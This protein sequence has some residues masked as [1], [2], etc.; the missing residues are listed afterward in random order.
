M[1]NAA[2]SQPP[3]P[4]L[5]PA[6]PSTSIGLKESQSLTPSQPPKLTRLS[7]ADLSIVRS[8][9]NGNHDLESNATRIH[10]STL[11]PPRSLPDGLY[12]EVVRSRVISQY[13]FIISTLI[14]NI[15]VILQVLL[16]ATV[17]ALGSQT[18][19]HTAITVLA[20]ANT[21]NAGLLA[22]IHNSGLPDRFRNDWN[23]FDKVEMFL[24]ELMETGIV[25]EGWD[26]DQV[27]ADCFHRYTAAK[28]TIWQNKPATYSSSTSSMISTSPT[29]L[30]SP[31][32][33]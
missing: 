24:R 1:V 22:L 20:A 8:V 26:R 14:F 18:Q 17:T 13:Q 7:Q 31:T 10:S 23:E 27:I 16:G 5:S 6:S 11:Y 29:T 30:T 9:L 4:S 33:S 3:I 28:N 32:T 25:K 19:Q 21:V 15:S 2:P 12:K